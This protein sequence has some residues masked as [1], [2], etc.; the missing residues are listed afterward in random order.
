MRFFQESGYMN[1]CPLKRSHFLTAVCLIVTLVI[2]VLVAV[3]GANETECNIVS[4]LQNLARK[5][6]G[7]QVFRIV[8]YL[9]D[10]YMWVIFTSIYSIYAY[11]KSRKHLDTAIELA[12]FLIITTALIYF[13]KMVFARPRPSCPGISAYDDDVISSFSYPSGHVSRA[14]GA[15]AILSRG[16]RTKESLAIMAISLVS[17]SRI[18]LGAHYL[19][20]V[21]GGIFLSLAAQRLAS[22]SLPLL[23]RKIEKR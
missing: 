9:G 7:L 4:N 1:G 14:A 21:V 3:A 2:G 12:I 8:T 10:F 6:I 20:D 18:I 16:S 11:I 17:L 15:F 13:T 23:K 5:T 22:L 19:T